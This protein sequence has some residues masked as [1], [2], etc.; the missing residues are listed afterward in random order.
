MKVYVL[1]EQYPAYETGIVA[2]FERLSSAERHVDWLLSLRKDEED[3]YVI[4][5][6]AVERDEH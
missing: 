6:Y 3:P 2:V 4:E 1:I 5:S